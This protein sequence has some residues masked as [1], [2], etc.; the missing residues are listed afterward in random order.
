M[1]QIKKELM[2]LETEEEKAVEAVENPRKCEASA[3]N[4][5][6]ALN[7]EFLL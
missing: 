4:E 1:K 7:S 6:E 2:L 3:V 5:V